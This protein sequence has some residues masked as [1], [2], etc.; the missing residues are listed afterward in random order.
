MPDKRKGP[1]V[2]GFIK[3][4]WEFVRSSDGFT[5][6]IPRTEGTPRIAKSYKKIRS[7]VLRLFHA[8]TMDED[9]KGQLLTAAAVDNA[10]EVA[11]AYAERQPAIPIHLRAAYQDGAVYLDLADEGNHIVEVTSRG[12]SV[13]SSA[14]RL[15]FPLFR[16]SNATQA[17][18]IPTR[19]GSVDTL[20]KILRFK[21]TDKRWLLIR[22]WLIGALF[23]DVPR[24]MLWLTGAQGSGKSTRAR[25][26]LSIFEPTDA[27]S[28]EPGR[29]H[30]DDYTAAH[31]RFLVS[32][33]NITSISASTSDWLCRIVTGVTDDKRGLYTDD[34]LLAGTI[35]RS[36]VAT[37][38]TLPHGLGSDALQR[39]VLVEAD[40]LP[41]DKRRTER[42]LW[43]LF[44]THHAAILGAILDDLVGVLAN[45][46]AARRTER[47]P[48]MA[49]YGEVL[50]A[51]D[52][53][54]GLDGSASSHRAAYEESVN[55]TLADR[56]YEDPLIA[57]LAE[58][59]QDEGDE[60]SGSLK[61]LLG[62][63]D[64][65]VG[66]TDRDASWPKNEAALRARLT[67][68]SEAMRSVGVVMGD[69]RKS[70]GRRSRSF[71]YREPG[72]ECPS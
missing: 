27:L 37:S 1:D 6:A 28:R 45:R 18:P 35:R 63:L 17:L 69:A 47:L 31:S 62:V 22:G 66:L 13:H 15:D 60:W 50:T 2:Y 10:L 26:V 68:A 72:P 39:L 53:H 42:Q 67:K 64:T 32:Y 51:L 8:A 38:I 11:S 36:G 52:M 4:N 30:R 55:V 19:G 24:P 40:R 7:D 57:A 58:F 46:D 20:R 56:A 25:M 59:V 34:D 21:E 14:D 41:D 12:W 49:D 70:N 3:D 29:N 61:E 44:H 54:L 9:G 16:R 71:T 65:R 33:D 48:R 5:Y 23:A 43:A